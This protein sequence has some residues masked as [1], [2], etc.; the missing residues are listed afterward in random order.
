[1]S[2]NDSLTRKQRRAIAALLESR[3]IEDAAKATQVSERT[4]FRWL[5]EPGFV[6]ALNV[7][8]SGVISEA[9]R[10][11]IADLKANHGTLRTLRDDLKLPASVRLRAAQALDDSLLRWKELQNTDERLAGLELLVAQRRWR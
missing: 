6:Q 8:E 4:L 10:A 9:V 11:L 3:T 2:Q 7:A 5:A 1:M